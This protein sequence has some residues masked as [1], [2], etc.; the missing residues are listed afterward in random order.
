VKP[1]RGA[2]ASIKRRR[3]GMVKKSAPWQSR[4]KHELRH[5]E[6]ECVRRFPSRST[7]VAASNLLS[8]QR[9]MLT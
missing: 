8:R 5:V 3:R 7:P 9:L 1:E 4:S 2:M 6:H